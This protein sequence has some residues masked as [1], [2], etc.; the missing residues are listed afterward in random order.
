MQK[1]WSQAIIL[2]NEMAK[3]D[4]EV[5]DII[6][7]VVVEELKPEERLAGLK[8][9]ERLADLSEEQ[10]EQMLRLLQERLKKSS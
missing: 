2:L 8:P 9:E 6:M 5:K 10:Q 1:E 4:P 3:E 7:R